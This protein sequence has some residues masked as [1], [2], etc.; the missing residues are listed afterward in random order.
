MINEKQFPALQKLAAFSGLGVM[1][2][3]R[4]RNFIEVLYSSH[5]NTYIIGTA[6]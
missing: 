2:Q 5:I 3:G 6:A 4:G 1:K